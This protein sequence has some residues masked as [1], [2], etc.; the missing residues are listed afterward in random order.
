MVRTAR[1][2]V[3]DQNIKLKSGSLTKKLSGGLPVSEG[4]PVAEFGTKQD[5]KTTYARKSKGGGSHQVTRRTRHAFKP[6]NRKGY[7]VYPAAAEMIPR[8]A[9]LWVQTT[10]RTFYEALERK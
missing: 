3:S 9:S 8:I 1:V 2:Q 5:K 7:V 6:L 10:I 4:A